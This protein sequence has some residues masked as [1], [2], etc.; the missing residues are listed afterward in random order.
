MSKLH[1]AEE[2]HKAMEC[3]TGKPMEVYRVACDLFAERMNQI[4]S[5]WLTSK[6]SL[7]EAINDIQSA[8]LAYNAA[9]TIAFKTVADQYNDAI[10]KALP[11]VATQYNDGLITHQEYIYKAL[12][13]LVS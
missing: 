11:E 8:A 4:E 6:A 13:A 12:D 7:I 1:L 2:L 9:M 3:K 5:P 10:E